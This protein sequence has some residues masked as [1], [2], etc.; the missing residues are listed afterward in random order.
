MDPIWTDPERMSGTPCFTGTRVPVY[1]LF[2]ALRQDRSIADFLRSFPTVDRE[3]ALAVLGMAAA[4]V[5]PP[6]LPPAELALSG[7]E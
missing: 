3:Q 5:I 2:D 7:A 4:A 6:S 1:N